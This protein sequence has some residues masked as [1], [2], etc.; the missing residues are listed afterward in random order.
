MF[1]IYIR[2]LF[3]EIDIERDKE[4]NRVEI[5]KP[6]YLDDIGIRIASKSLKTN[7]EILQEIARK[8][9]LWGKKNGIEFDQ[10]KT[11]LIHFYKVKNIIEEDEFLI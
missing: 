9:I 3:E 6:S 8:L 10:E 4:G 7:C 5:S 11:E 2:F 1:L